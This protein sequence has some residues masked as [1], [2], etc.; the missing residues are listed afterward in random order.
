[1]IHIAC[2]TYLTAFL[3]V[4]SQS[5]LSEVQHRSLHARITPS[6]TSLETEPITTI[7]EHIRTKLRT[8]RLELYGIAECVNSA[9]PASASTSQ[10]AQGSTQ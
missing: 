1:M 4:A 10:Q 7:I 5:M 3:E 8:K 9:G 6:N 2:L